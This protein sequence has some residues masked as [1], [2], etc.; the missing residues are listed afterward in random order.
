MVRDFVVA[1]M[2]KKLLDLSLAQPNISANKDNPALA[3]WAVGVKWD[4]TFR[5]EEA[6]TFKGIF[7]NQNIV[8]SMR[9]SD[10]VDFLKRQFGIKDSNG[11]RSIWVP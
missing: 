10:T 9:D 3:E 11:N 2:G 5:R 6:K 4:K 1:E 8:C 7:A